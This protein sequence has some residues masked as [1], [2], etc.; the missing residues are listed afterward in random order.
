VAEIE[1]GADTGLG[2]VLGDDTR[3]HLAASG[4]GLDARLR[5][6]RKDRGGMVF[7]PGE[8]GGIAQQAVFS[9]LGIACR[10]FAPW[11]RIE[12]GDVDED[13]AGLMEGANEVLAMGRIDAGLAADGG[14]D[15]RQKSGRD[16]D[17]VDTAP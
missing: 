17:E 13:G 8:E 2:L 9:D 14:I 1:K 10:Q 11:Q 7:E 15:L 12:Q 3:L 4:D 16:L 5:I 6:A